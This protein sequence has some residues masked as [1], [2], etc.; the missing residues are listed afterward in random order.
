MAEWEAENADEVQ[1]WYEDGVN[2]LGLE[3]HNNEN[4]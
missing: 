3:P 2:K 4:K 1:E